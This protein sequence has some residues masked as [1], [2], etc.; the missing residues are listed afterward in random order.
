MKTQV[1]D[2]G[3]QRAVSLT[4]GGLSVAVLAALGVA[5][6]G[7]SGSDA[8]AAQTTISSSSVQSAAADAAA[9]VTLCRDGSAGA[10]AAPGPSALVS[11]ALGVMQRRHLQ[12]LGVG[13]MQAL[14]A[15]DPLVQAGSCGGQYR[16]EETPGSDMT[17]TA[18]LTFASFC[19]AG[20]SASEQEVVDGTV[21]ISLTKAVVAGQE[22]LT[23]F[24]AD[25]P[26]GLT[27][28]VRT[29]T[30]TV[31]QTETLAFSDMVYTVGVSGG[32]PTEAS[33]DRVT[34]RELTRTHNGKTYRQTGYVFTSWDTTDGGSRMTLAGRGYRSGGEWFDISTPTPI[35]QDSAGG[36]TGGTVR[37]GGAGG[38]EAL[39]TV[40]PAAVPLATMTVNG[41]AYTEG[42]PACR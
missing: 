3:P 37:F 42:L 26:A 24:A 11:R 7:G 17:S 27:A 13:H 12:R 4:I 23:R 16:L 31:L 18:T 19:E 41:T 21:T 28:V 29:T 33:P 38:T 35:S 40:Q 6:G 10:A 20:T 34:I 9:F 5:C 39:I 30:G 36:Y 32:S 22:V 2:R 8:G 25:S 15:G 1:R 14:A